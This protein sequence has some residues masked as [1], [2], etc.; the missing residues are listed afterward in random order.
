M[1]KILLKMIFF[2]KSKR[3]LLVS[4][5]LVLR[6]MR[7]NGNKERRSERRTNVQADEMTILIN[8]KKKTFK[9]HFPIKFS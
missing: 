1:K 3:N 5:V 2:N 4:L 6:H 8:Q 9:N 7:K